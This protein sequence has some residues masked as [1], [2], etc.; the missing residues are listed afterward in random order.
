MHNTV[1]LDGRPQSEIRGPFHWR[2]AANGSRLVW[3]TGAGFDYA[4][5][6]HD[7]YLPVI[8][9]RGVLSVHGVGWVVIDHIL[10]PPGAVAAAEAFWHVHPDW[11]AAAAGDAVTF[12]H[13][14]GSVCALSSTSE[15]EV[16]GRDNANGLDD[17]APEYG[18]IERATCVRGRS[19]GPLPRSVAT[20]VSSAASTPPRLSIKAVP[21]TAS[22][23]PAWHSTAFRLSWAGREAIVLSSI[24]RAPGKGSAGGPGQVWGC[25]DA[26][27]DAR[28]ALVEVG[29][30]V[31]IGPILI[32]GSVVQTPLASSVHDAVR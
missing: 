17:Y 22:A 11:R 31:I 26:R 23:G 14:D 24:E 7:G 32:G 2:S 30:P 10:G 12:R 9:A 15:V 21:V 27:T 16:L 4:E 18:R 5:G 8:H 28:F 13:R 6:M 19:D 29:G 20:A 25:D 1:V 3:S